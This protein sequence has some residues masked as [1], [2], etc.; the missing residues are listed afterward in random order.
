MVHMNVSCHPYE[1]V[2]S[3]V[4]WYGTGIGGRHEYVMWNTMRHVTHINKSHLSCIGMIQVSEDVMNMY[5]RVY[6]KP[7]DLSKTMVDLTAQDE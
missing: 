1:W 6:G 2:T 7:L 4:Y 5:E 3:L